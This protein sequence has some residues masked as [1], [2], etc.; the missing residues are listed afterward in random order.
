M[1]QKV[2]KHKTRET[3]RA[4]MR[5]TL[6]PSQHSTAP[7]GQRALGGLLVLK[8]GKLGATIASSILLARSS[9]DLMLPY[10]TRLRRALE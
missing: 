7:F 8:L 5:L 10:S 3:A 1:Q 2:T 4:A 9:G 6:D